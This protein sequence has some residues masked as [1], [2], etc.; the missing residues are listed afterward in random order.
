[1]RILGD[2]A[3]GGFGRVERVALPDG[4]VVARKVFAPSPAVLAGA[5]A[6]DVDKLR[7]R[8][9]REVKM[10]SALG[11]PSVMPVLAHDLTGAEPWYTMPLADRSYHDQ[12]QAE[13][14]A[15]QIAHGPLADILNALD[16]IHRLGYTHRDLKPRNVLLHDGKWKLSD[17]G[18]AMPPSGSTTRF[19]SVDS[20]WGTLNYMA[21]EQ[22]K[23]FARVGPTADLYAFGCI[24]HDAFAPGQ[25][26]TPFG[27]ATAPGPIG[28]VIEKCTEPMVGKRFPSVGVLRPALLTVLAM[29]S[30]PIVP[31][32]Q[33]Q[34]WL[35]DLPNVA[36]WTL[37]K[38]DEFARYL[39]E[40]T[41]SGENEPI[42]S[43]LDEGVLQVLATK[44]PLVGE[45]IAQAYCDWVKG[46]GFTFST[47]DVIIHRVLALFA[48]GTLT[49][50]AHAA[51]AAAELG[52]SHNR[53]YVM[54]ELV[55]A[56]G[57]GLANDA[58][59]RIALEIEIEGA[60]RNF[61]A[62]AEKLRDASIGDYHPAIA[63]VL[64][65]YKA[66]GGAAD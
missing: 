65:R 32:A 7:A 30:A 10:Q 60:H 1:M 43:T 55:T 64:H 37:D 29:P 4:T 13:V 12:L 6:A 38:V 42:F 57:H 62:C 61:V 26:R 54:R 5:T 14:A 56:C 2:I 49:A 11:G 17:F 50:K 40:V 36:A 45:G 51:L 34:Q 28:R 59:E 15:G 19:T 53:W 52:R 21:P 35:A 33:E 16:H 27:K 47:C 46:T 24:L 18:L 31:S 22:A 44:D 66:A 58:A 9:A 41:P 8:F 25:A 23:A 20:S 63:A 39:A 3:R 48:H